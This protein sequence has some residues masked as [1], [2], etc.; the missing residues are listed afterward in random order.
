[1]GLH[2]F[3]FRSKSV[4]ALFGPSQEVRTTQKLGY[5]FGLDNYS[6]NNMAVA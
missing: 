1:M 3:V 2:R 6:G 4:V 5:L